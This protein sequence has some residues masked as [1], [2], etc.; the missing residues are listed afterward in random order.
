MDQLVLSIGQY[1][2]QIRFQSMFTTSLKQSFLALCRTQS[3]A[4]QATMMVLH[5]VVRGNSK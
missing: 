5:S 4:S 3:V 2:Q 1:R